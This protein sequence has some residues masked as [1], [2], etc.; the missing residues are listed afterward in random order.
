MSVSTFI[1]DV[2]LF[3]SYEIFY[4]RTRK[5]WP[6][7]T[8]G[9][10]IE[11]TTWAGLTVIYILCMIQDF[12]FVGFTLPWT[13]FELTTSVVIGTDCTGS[14]KSNYHTI[15][16]TTAPCRCLT[17]YLTCHKKQGVL[18]TTLCD[19]V[20]QWL[21]TAQWF[22]LGTPVSSTNKTD[23]Y[24]ITEIFNVCNNCL[25]EETFLLTHHLMTDTIPEN[26]IGQLTKTI[27]NSTRYNIMW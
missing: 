2:I 5:S 15:T 14:C 9:C 16:T 27:C 8:D 1:T 4:D 23:C 18:D 19:I 7:L 13:G 26:K 12:V 24:D 25:T 6:F 21:V 10:L 20:C 17:F 11:M 22:S 3:I